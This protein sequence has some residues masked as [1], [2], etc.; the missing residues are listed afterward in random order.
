M[1]LRGK[2]RSTSFDTVFSSR[3]YSAWISHAR[4]R[5][6]SCKEVK[7]NALKSGQ[8]W[9]LSFCMSFR[10]VRSFFLF[11]QFFTREFQ[12][13]NISLSLSLPLA[14]SRRRCRRYRLL[15]HPYDLLRNPRA[16]VAGQRQRRREL[17]RAHPPAAAK[18]GAVSAPAAGEGDEAR[19]RDP[20]GIDGD[21]DRR[22]RGGLLCRVGVRGEAHDGR[23]E[24]GDDDRNGGAGAGVVARFAVSFGG[25]AG[26]RGGPRRS[27]GSEGDG[28]EDWHP[29]S[30][31]SGRLAQIVLD[32]DLRRRGFFLAVVSV[33]LGHLSS[34]STSPYDG[35][36]RHPR[37][38]ERRG[39][40]GGGGCERGRG[41]IER[42]QEALD[43]QVPRGRS[44]GDA[45][46]AEIE[47][48]RQRRRRGSA[49]AAA[50]TAERRG[51]GRCHLGGA[52]LTRAAKP[53]RP[54]ARRDLDGDCDGALVRGRGQRGLE[55]DLRFRFF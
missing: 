55:L 17:R 49:R 44:L 6:F 22:A 39:D 7:L 34:S 28:D 5:F 14:R 2:R 31:D 3:F 9:A 35:D 38:G 8:Q 19:P 54:R 16:H 33:R 40:G 20:G 32:L 36:R 1:L 13:K 46:G 25:D 30:I 37:V 4:V 45:E 41:A 26:A 23:G 29:R 15:G 24:G 48:G 53:L 50:A 21:G 47:G 51:E 43:P 42:Q 12:K 11:L 27:R 18:A 52:L 10:F